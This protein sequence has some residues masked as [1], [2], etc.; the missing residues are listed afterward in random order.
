MILLAGSALALA[1]CGDDEGGEETHATVTPQ[2]AIEEIA[3][4]R[5][6][7]A[8][9]LEEYTAGDAETHWTAWS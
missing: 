4:V 8:Q 9:A 1:A 2:A 3:A 6:G 5:A 7:L